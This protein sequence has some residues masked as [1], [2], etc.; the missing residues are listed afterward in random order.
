VGN[1]H[2]F[3]QQDNNFIIMRYF[4]L[5]HIKAQDNL[6]LILN[7]YMK[8]LSTIDQ[9]SVP[10]ETMGE[11]MRLLNERSSS[12]ARETPSSKECEQMFDWRGPR[13]FMLQVLSN[14]L[15]DWHKNIGWAIKALTK[16]FEQ[17]PDGDLTRYAIENRLRVID[18]YGS[19][20]ETDWEEDGFDAQG[21]QKWKVVY[22]DDAVALAN[23]SLA[24]NIEQYFTGSD[25][26]GEKIGTSHAPDYAYF[27]SLVRRES[28][29]C[30]LK[31][32]SAVFG[33]DLPIYK[34]NDA[35]EMVEQSLADQVESSI[36]EDI[37]N[38]HVIAWFELA[39]V[40]ANYCVGLQAFAITADHYR[41]L[42][43]HLVRVRDLDFP[44]PETYI[45]DPVAK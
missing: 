30:P 16:F 27:T 2:L 13:F 40:Q 41:E 15:N 4:T 24:N 44:K 20:D 34:Q 45:L 18:E 9:L 29:F 22:K 36:N 39:L 17:Y 10:R 35:G 28:D 26:N 21:E 25:G 14:S 8:A 23:Y 12:Q 37:T 5:K 43:N 38:A 7:A 1:A 6:A 31:M 42:L 19:D 33:K 32:I 11:Y 3:I